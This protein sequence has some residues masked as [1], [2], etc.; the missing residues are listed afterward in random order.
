MQTDLFKIRRIMREEFE[1]F[2]VE[3]LEAIA[4]LINNGEVAGEESNSKEV[5]DINSLLKEIDQSP[6]LTEWEK[7]Q[8]EKEKEMYLAGEMTEEEYN[9]RQQEWENRHIGGI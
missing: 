3:M 2:K 7:T 9:R 8:R 4:S 5:A 6:T 1:N